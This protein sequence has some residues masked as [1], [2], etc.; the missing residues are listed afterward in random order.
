V[1]IY[2]QRAMDAIAATARWTAAIRARES[3][4]PDR[5]FD[6]PLAGQEGFARLDAEPEVARDNPFVVIRT[7][8]FDDW[9]QR[10]AASGLRQVVLVAAGMDT[11]A[12]RLPW[13]PGTILWE[14]DRSELLE[15]KQTLL[16]GVNARPACDRRPV[17]I[18]LASSGLPVALQDAGFDAAS[19]S[20]WLAEGFFEYL[21]AADVLRLLT[22]IASLAPSGSRLGLDLP[23]QDFLQHEWMQP[24]LREL[25]RQGTPWRFGTNSPETLLAAHGWRAAVTEPGAEGAHFGR[26]PWPVLPREQPGWPRSFLIDAVRE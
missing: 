17:G 19:P 15:L 10:M 24:Y 8:F 14:L 5:L 6:D 13:P 12:F 1:F 25:E 20:A 18:D 4:R 3:E 2:H 11:R 9:V 26:W 23:S 21:E 16:E 7:R 22:T